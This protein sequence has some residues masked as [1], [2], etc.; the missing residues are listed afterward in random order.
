MTGEGPRAQALR[1][2][3]IMAARTDELG[4]ALLDLEYR[5]EDLHRQWRDLIGGTASQEAKDALIRLA[6]VG[7]KAMRASTQAA[8]SADN[9]R[10]WARSI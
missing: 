9:M 1:A 4:R 3:E 8:L 5:A 7:D 10:R 2:I 6:D